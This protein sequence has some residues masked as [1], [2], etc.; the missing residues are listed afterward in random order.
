MAGPGRHDPRTIEVDDGCLTILQ[1]LLGSK[2][3][4]MQQTIAV[5]NGNWISARR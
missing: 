1:K 5:N 4:A 3:Q 2:L